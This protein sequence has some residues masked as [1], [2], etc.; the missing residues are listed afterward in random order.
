MLWSEEVQK[1]FTSIQT[2]GYWDHKN[3]KGSILWGDARQKINDI[4]DD[5]T[6]DL[7][8]LD[9]FSPTKCPMLWSEEFLFKLAKKLAPCGRLITYSS[10]AAVRSSLRRAGLELASQLPMNNE[11]RRWS[12]GTI[13]ISKNK[14]FNSFQNY[15]RS[16]P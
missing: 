7:I 3:N 8:L 11:T 1:I 9:A 4:P 10:A 15:S 2:T 14:I 5:L 12:N 6:F 16:Q 13:G